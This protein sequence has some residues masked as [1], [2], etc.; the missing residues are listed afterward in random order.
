MYAEEPNI[1][2]HN[3]VGTFTRVSVMYITLFL[4]ELQSGF[5]TGGNFQITK[6]HKDH[7]FNSQLQNKKKLA[8]EQIN[9]LD[10]F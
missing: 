5:R 7:R 2:I 9:Q 8:G 3:F 10:I 4:Y 6:D 1:D